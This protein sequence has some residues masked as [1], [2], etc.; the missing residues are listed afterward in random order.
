MSSSELMWRGLVLVWLG[1]GV[2]MVLMV[3][4]RLLIGQLSRWCARY[5][6][7]SAVPPVGEV[8]LE[9]ERVAAIA[10]AVHAYRSR[11]HR[12]L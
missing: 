2:L 12:G 5:R 9:P 3:C 7:V 1:M 4:L 11:S 8:G 6:P 10:A